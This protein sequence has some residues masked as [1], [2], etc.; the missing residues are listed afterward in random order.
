[1]KKLLRFLPILILIIGLGIFFYF[2]LY[3]FISFDVIKQHHD[4]WLLWASTHPWLSAL[5][6]IVFYAVAVAFS[7]PGATFFTLTAGFI[8]GLWWGTLYV[9][10]GA[11]VGATCVFWAA[12]TAFASWLQKKSGAWLSKMESGFRRDAFHYLLVLRLIPIFPFW[13]IN[14]VPGLLGMR[15]WAYVIATFIGIIPG[16][17]VYVSVGNGLGALFDQDQTPNLSVIF[18]PEVLLPLLGLAVLSIIPVIYKRIKAKK[19]PS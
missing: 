4:Q 18:S 10:I 8:F 19:A 7:I 15:F 14:I 3:R 17:F 5:A 13:L 1:M 16:T 11:T 9:L 12:R 6:F 2:R